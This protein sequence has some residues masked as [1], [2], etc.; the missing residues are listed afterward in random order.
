MSDNQIGS[1]SFIIGLV[2]AIVLG[3]G[4]TAEY[5]KVVIWILFSIGIIVGALNVTAKETQSFLTTGTILALLPYLGLQVGVFND[6]PLVV[7]ILKA[8][9]TMFI[10]ATIIVALKAVYEVARD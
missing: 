8:I 2:V 7:N 6:A 9:L 5:N 10:P 4:L 3:L 1:W